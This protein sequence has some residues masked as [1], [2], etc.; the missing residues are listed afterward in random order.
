M[1]TRLGICVF[2][3]AITWLV[4]GQT[5]GHD[6][7]NFD[8]KTYVY[9]NPVV[10]SGLTWPGIAWAFIHSHALN[11]H[12]LT[13]ISHMFDCQVFGLNAGGHH[14]TNVL[15][16]T[17]AVIL[18]LLVLNQMT[19]Q[20]WRSAFVAAVFAIHPLHVESV[21][22]IAERKDVLSAVFFMLTLGAYVGYTRRRTI[23][24]YVTM[25]ILFA[26]GLMSKPMLVTVPFVLLLLD[27]WPLDRLKGQW[28]VVIGLVV[29]KLPLFVLS[30]ASCVVTIIAQRG[31]TGDMEPLP[32]IWRIENAAVSCT[33]YIGQ[34]FW[35]VKLAVFY[36]AH[37]F[38][39]WQIVFAFGFLIAVSAITVAMRKRHPYLFTG[40][41]WYLGMLVPVIGVLQIGLQSHAD[42][43]TYL[44]QIGLY[45]LATWTVADMAIFRGREKFLAAIAAILLLAPGWQSWKQTKYWK[46][47]ETL[48]THTLAVTS[49]NDIAHNNL[50]QFLAER[51]R[52]DG[53]IAQ[54]QA[55]LRI[56][57][58]A[59]EA[60]YN[61][62]NALVHNN[63]GNAFVEKE[64][65]DEA[66]AQYEKAIALRPDYADGHF[67]L[68]SVF[69]QQGRLDEAI[70][71]WRKTLSIHPDDVEG[72]TMLGDA[73]V[74]THR[75]REGISHYEKVLQLDPR[76][77]LTL[78]KLAW[79]SATSADASLRDGAKAIE[80]ARK[81]NHYSDEKNPIVMRTLAAAYADA[82][83]FDDAIEIAQRAAG[84]ADALGQNSLAIKL[85]QDVDLYRERFPLRDSSLTNAESNE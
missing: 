22:W 36:P 57:G 14:F 41:F 74:R 78:N 12:P 51:G 27:Y 29:E 5:L 43:Y 85:A 2:L 47:S 65:L 9:G 75:I 7:V 38:S 6:F 76:S 15:L 60:R 32:F 13:T 64:R 8:D 66:I 79:I 16:H 67:N 19:A 61:L 83:R 31:S 4:F 58:D 46:N 72:H 21:A 45:V 53:A 1:K 48:W 3:V 63:L 37:S 10:T 73:L 20:L 55:A 77:I 40:W 49:D 33:T 81:A 44:P 71:E 68:G 56:R 50:G 17:I 39:V 24:R 69:L 30:A 42:R 52:I 35:P 84:L 80:L 18:L 23:G 25:S 82:G 59:Q 26:C 54:Y 11:W 34:M 62:S 70:A 28:S